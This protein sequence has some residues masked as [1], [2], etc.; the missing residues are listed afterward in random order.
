MPDYSFISLP[1]RER[2]ARTLRNRFVLKADGWNDFGSYVR[3]DL[4]YFD[5]VGQRSDYGKVKV[6]HRV[7]YA[8]TSVV[9]KTT[10]LP[11]AFSE[12]P[13]GFISLGQGEEYYQRLGADFGA[14]EAVEVLRA[15]RDV[16]LMPA[17]A[18]EFETSPR[19]RNAMMRTNGAQRA[20][21]F[22]QW[23]VRGQE[24]RIEPA[25]EYATVIGGGGVPTETRFD[26]AP[27][28]PLPGRI[29]AII[30]RNAVGKTVFMSEL[31]AD[32]S[33]I[34]R[35]SEER[36]ALRLE[37]FPGGRPV[38]ARVIAVSYSAFDRFRRPEA[39][40][41][42]SYVYCGIRDERGGIS[43]R[44][45]ARSYDANRERI[46]GL[47]R[48]RDWIRY[49][50]AILGEDRRITPERL[51]LEIAPRE[52]GDDV[53]PL[54]DELSSGQAILCHFVTA[55]LAWL[56]SE[57]LV[58][59]DEPETHLHP[60]AVASLFLVLTRMLQ[61]FESYAVVATH[62]P[63][64]LQEIP[65]SR[66]LH[67]VRDAGATVGDELSIESFG[68]SI[69]ELTRHVFD[70]VEVKSLHKDVLAGLAASMSP[71]EVLELFPKGLGMAAQSY[72][73]GLYGSSRGR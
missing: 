32:L 38:F 62:S 65:S 43:Q 31:A 36:L 42:S 35:I 47:E 33:Q 17:L 68:E 23:W 13:E 14:A 53:E 3:F 61:E 7:P 16:A 19:Y 28:D 52:E 58:L 21:R 50:L 12:L 66:V 69:T 70:T 9:E 1:D 41:S 44:A 11:K 49:V 40:P 64:V 45:L 71:E 29:V 51:E 8:T 59:F 63:V 46:R 37:R 30:G 67:F 2:P 18:A 55:L 20:I 6:L 60:N 10:E 15:L 54:L 24:V 34:D 26:F 5:G 22:G 57:S 27:M 56:T 25:F 73:I 4:L 39:T 72:L 48:N